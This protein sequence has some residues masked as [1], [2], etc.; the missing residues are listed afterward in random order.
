M[1]TEKNQLKIQ[2]QL[3]KIGQK[4]DLADFNLSEYLPI[5]S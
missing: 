3:L 1:E 4:L 5:L 2:K